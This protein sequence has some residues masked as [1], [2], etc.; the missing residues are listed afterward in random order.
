MNRTA[1][2]DSRPA[3]RA[4]VAA[5]A[6]TLLAAMAL[7]GC[8][9]PGRKIAYSPYEL[10]TAV[11][12]QVPPERRGDV[13]VPYQ[14]TPEMVERAERYVGGYTTEYGRANR[15][16]S[17]M[18]DGSAFDLDWEPVTTTIPADT[19]SR[20]YGN[21]LSLTSMYV[22]LARA[23]GLKAYYVDA[24]DRVNDLSREDQLLVDTGHIAAT[25][26]TERGWSMVDFSGEISSFRTFRVIDDVEALAHFYNNR[27]YERI[28]Q[29]KAADESDESDDWRAALDDFAMAVAVKADFARAHNN[30]GVAYSRLGRGEDAEQS[31]RAAIA[32]DDDFSPPYHNLGNLYM[33]REQFDEAIH[34]YGVAIESRSKNPYLHYHYG[35]AL[36][37]S[38]DVEGSIRSF[39]RA[40]AL[41]QDYREPRNLL[42]QAYRSQGRLDD[43]ERVQRAA[44]GVR[45][46]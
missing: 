33:R 45:Q 8:S 43:A 26:R 15:L 23:I 46:Q 32:A 14:V 39:E 35:L 41:K 7:T 21:C 28:V 31:Y 12:P 13:L 22:G 20:G 17:A 29:A 1:S 5:S 4:L 10:R 34:W 24:S 37:R 2:L 27:G 9:S 38:G 3:R 16:R 30:L 40:I 11:A 19:M 25:I 42:A 18:T 36:Y 44:G 6:A